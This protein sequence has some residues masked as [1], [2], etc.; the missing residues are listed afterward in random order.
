MGEKD[1][2]EKMVYF[3]EEEREMIEAFE[4]DFDPAR[5]VSHLTP[6]RK[7]ELQAMARATLADL[8]AKGGDKA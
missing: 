4:R 6:E 8:R 5:A 2:T 3:D 1:D 7:A